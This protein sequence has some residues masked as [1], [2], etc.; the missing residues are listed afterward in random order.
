MSLGDENVRQILVDPSQFAGDWR[1]V[2]SEVSAS[3]LSWT[4]LV[5]ANPRRIAVVF[6]IQGVGNATW[7]T[8]NTQP[9]AAGF[10]VP[11]STNQLAERLTFSAFGGMVQGPIFVLGIGGVVTIEVCETIWLPVGR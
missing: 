3:N 11:T 4:P 1:V 7:I 5:A 2:H 10:Q 6:Q 9:L 8:D